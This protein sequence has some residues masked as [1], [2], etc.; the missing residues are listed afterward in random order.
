MWHC[1]GWHLP[2]QLPFGMKKSEKQNEKKCLPNV[3]AADQS[4]E[5][6]QERSIRTQ[7]IFDSKNATRTKILTQSSTHSFDSFNHFSST[8]IHDS[9]C[10]AVVE[11]EFG[12]RSPFPYD[13]SNQTW[14][15]FNALCASMR[16]RSFALRW[17]GHWPTDDILVLRT[18]MNGADSPTPPMFP[19]IF[20]IL[21]IM[22]S[23][24]AVVKVM[25]FR[26][27]HD[28][29]MRSIHSNTVY[30]L[31][32]TQW[33]QLCVMENRCYRRVEYRRS[34]NTNEMIFCAVQHK[35]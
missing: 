23:N 11:R 30:K 27:M 6:R 26:H 18:P 14:I 21:F 28:V 5:R 20:F 15:Y 35:Q 29:H 7:Y 31:H 25:D 10:W 32:N 33:P 12:F 8:K 9:H 2:L 24:V 16:N 22:D 17:F 34:T 13:Q 19:F 3:L 4:D 1:I